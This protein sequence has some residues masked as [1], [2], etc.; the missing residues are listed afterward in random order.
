MGIL[1]LFCFL[2]AIGFIGS[3]GFVFGRMCR[4]SYKVF[5]CVLVAH[6]GLLEQDYFCIDLPR[7]LLLFDTIMSHAYF[8][9]NNMSKWLINWVGRLNKSMVVICNFL[10]CIVLCLASC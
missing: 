9:C 10:L 6:L 4:N 1:N 8:W 2:M 5:L 7:K 3:K